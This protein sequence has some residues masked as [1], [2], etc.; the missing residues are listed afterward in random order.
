M[1]VGLDMLQGFGAAASQFFFVPFHRPHVPEGQK[2]DLSRF[3]L[4]FE[5]KFEGNTLD[6]TKWQSHG[7]GVRRGGYWDLSQA[8]VQDGR[9]I[10]RTEYRDGN[11]G[12]GW[13]HAG[14][15]TR[16]LFEQKYGYFEAR[17]KLPKGQGLWSAFWMQCGGMERV[18]G[19][20]KS[21]AEIDIFE[22]PYY[23]R[24]Q[25]GLVTCNIHYDG[26]GRAHRTKNAGLIRVG[27]P[28]ETFHNYGVEWNEQEY[29][30]YLDG[31][32]SCRT[33]FG[34]PSQ[35][36]EFL[37]LSTEVDGK[38]GRPFRGWSGDIRRNPEEVWPSDFVVE[39]VRA[40]QYRA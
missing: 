30:F 6:R 31:V 21:G 3:A 23:A 25:N 24:R 22:S 28:Y 26:Y 5:D 27:N 18:T 8:I 19:N 2:L 10:I 4:T 20:G 13:Y 34:Q 16:G 33:S 35:T 39:Y 1:K 36:P 14:L 12:P 37:I 7:E 15:E 40:Y 17:C 11:D 38:G 29:I 9:L 32:E